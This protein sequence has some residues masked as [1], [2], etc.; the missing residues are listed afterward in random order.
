MEIEIKPEYLLIGTCLI[1]WHGL[2][3]KG[4]MLGGD[5]GAVAALVTGIDCVAGMVVGCSSLEQKEKDKQS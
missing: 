3:I 5:A 1:V 2:I 4:F